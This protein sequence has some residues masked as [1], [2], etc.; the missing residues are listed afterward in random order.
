MENTCWYC[1]KSL[2]DGEPHWSIQAAREAT[3]GDQVEV[4]SAVVW[5]SLCERCAAACNLPAG[6]D[7][8]WEEGQL[9]FLLAHDTDESPHV[10]PVASARAA[11]PET[12]SPTHCPNCQNVIE[13][14]D[15]FCMMCGGAIR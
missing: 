15:S 14:D 5:L 9:T 13:P 6:P 1:E 7:I 8:S 3:H 12:A 11:D 4:E 10:T 2:T